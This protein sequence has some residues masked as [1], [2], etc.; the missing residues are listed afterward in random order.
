MS[1][2]CPTCGKDD[3][4]T[5]TAMKVHH[6][7]A[8]GESLV[9]PEI[10]ECN[11]CGDEFEVAENSG[12]KYC[13]LECMGLDKRDR[14]ELVCENCGDEFEVPPSDA[15]GRKF[16]SQ[17][18]RTDSM[19]SKYEYRSCEMCGRNF[20]TIR[21]GPAKYCCRS[22]EA[23]AK[24]EKPRPEDEDTLLWLLYVYEGF[25]HHKTWERQR[26]VQGAAD[27]L[28]KKEV[29]DRL[30]E[31]GVFNTHSGVSQTLAQMDPDE[32]G[33]STPDGD[34]TWKELYSTG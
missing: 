31:M 30:V 11:H 21:S 1:H 32:L 10:S 15:D 23:E 2:E 26:A 25:N 19:P 9:E 3:F 4:D 22:C 24:A 29:R 13:S 14:V 27:A 34:D 33:S 5:E 17:E 6:T 16:C 8:H 20:K 18:C 12:G 7:H 28:T